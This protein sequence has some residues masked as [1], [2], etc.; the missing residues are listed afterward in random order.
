MKRIMIYDVI[1]IG[2][3][4]AGYTVAAHLANLKDK[5][6]LIIERNPSPMRKLAITGKGRCNLTNDCDIETVLNNI[7]TNAR[8]MRS[9]LTAFTPRDTMAMFESLGVPL[10]TERGGRVF[11]QSDKSANVVEALRRASRAD[12]V[13]DRVAKVIKQGDFFKVRG[14]NTVYS[15]RTVVIA[16]GGVSYSKMGSSGDGYAL[17]QSFGHTIVPPRPTLVPLETIEDCAPLAGLTLKNVS[18]T[19]KQHDRTLFKEQG[20]LLFTHFGVSGPLVLSAS[21]FVTSPTDCRLFIDLKPALDDKT[22]DARILRDFATNKNRQFK[23]ALSGLLPEKFIDVFVERSGIAPDCRV[24][25]VSKTQRRRL[26]ELFKAFEL[27][28]T[29]TRPIDEAVITDGGVCVREIEPRTMQS[30]LVQGLYFAGEI[31]DVAAFTGGF[32]LQVAFST[33]YAV[34]R[35]CSRENAHNGD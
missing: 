5:R 23:N 16:T 9:S 14:K 3:G 17:A 24:N 21:C 2:G 34:G 32:N 33:A 31:L 15:A 10:K 11:P 27:T 4:A 26:V 6:V 30:K 35:A 1:I 7:F 18:L 22:L 13:T 8:F 29:A 25:E 12:V 19:L 20:E 28:V